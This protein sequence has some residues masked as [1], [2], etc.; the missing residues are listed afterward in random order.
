MVDASFMQTLWNMNPVSSGCE[1]VE[2]KLKDIQTYVVML[3]I[4]F[5]FHV[6]HFE[7]L[8]VLFSL[9]HCYSGYLTGGYVLR[10]FHGHMDECLAIP[11]ADQGDERK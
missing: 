8:L 3:V 10:L 2:G 9:F 7:C 1:L 4:L 6:L 5:Y 11:A